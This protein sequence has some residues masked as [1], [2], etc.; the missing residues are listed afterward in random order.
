MPGAVN[1]DDVY[2][3]GEHGLSVSHGQSVFSMARFSL[4][5]YHIVYTAEHSIA[6]VPRAWNARIVFGLVSR[7]ILLARKATRSRLRTTCD[8]TEKRLR[9]PPVVLPQIAASAERDLT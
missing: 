6:P 1:A 7:S 4:L 2:A 3:P 9:M 8:P 5:T